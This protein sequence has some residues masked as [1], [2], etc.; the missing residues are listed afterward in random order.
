MA[1]NRTGAAPSIADWANGGLRCA[2]E[3]LLVDAMKARILAHD[4]SVDG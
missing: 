4:A 3:K 2:F 1:V